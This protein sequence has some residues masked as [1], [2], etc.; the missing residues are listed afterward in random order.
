MKEIPALKEM[1]K[2][3]RQEVTDHPHH[4]HTT[5]ARTFLDIEAHLGSLYI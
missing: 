1:G 4:S 2:N 5:T 3:R